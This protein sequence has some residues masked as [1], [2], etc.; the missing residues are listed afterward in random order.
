MESTTKRGGWMVDRRP[1][2]GEDLFL[3]STPRLEV[4]FADQSI[5]LWVILQL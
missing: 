1:E 2:L 5:Q 3:K 4:P